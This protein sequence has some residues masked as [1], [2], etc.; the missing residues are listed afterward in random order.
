MFLSPASAG[1]PF[2]APNGLL[3]LGPSGTP[4][5]D[6]R[7]ADHT[8]TSVNKR[9]YSAVYASIVLCSQ[10]WFQPIWCWLAK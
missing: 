1:F 5:W 7:S 4:T 6:E 10:A 9:R 8:G 3:K 2:F